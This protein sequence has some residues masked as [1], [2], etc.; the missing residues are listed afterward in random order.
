MW[1]YNKDVAGDDIEFFQLCPP[2]ERTPIAIVTNI[3][4][5]NPQIDYYNYAYCLRRM[6]SGTCVYVAA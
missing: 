5:Y 1:H 6:T 2:E 4:Y 3:L